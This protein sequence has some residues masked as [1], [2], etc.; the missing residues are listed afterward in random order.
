MS[1]IDMNEEERC[2]MIERG[3]ISELELA[4]WETDGLTAAARMRMERQR[5]FL[6]AFAQN[7]IILMGLQ[8]AQCSRANVLQWREKEWF[9][10]LYQMAIEEAADRVEMEAYRR[11]VVGYDEP[12]IYQ[13]LPTT[14]ADPVTGEFKHLTIRKYSDT[15]MAMV[16]KGVRPEKYRDNHKVEIE[17]NAAGG[18]LIV[19]GTIDPVAWAKAAGEQQAKYAGNST[20]HD[21]QTTS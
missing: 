18:V 16:L 14:V 4:D 15:L 2:Y 17:G 6:R 21:G 11:A 12:V 13:G 20:D 8:A 10:T 5:L 3:P 19:P 9:E 7:G 1:V